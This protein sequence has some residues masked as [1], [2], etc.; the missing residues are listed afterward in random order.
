MDGAEGQEGGRAAA[1]W[2]RMRAGETAGPV[3]PQ[4]D[5]GIWFIGRLRTPWSDPCAC[6]R[7][8]DAAAG[9]LCRIELDPLWAE[10][11]D[12]LRPGPVQLLYWMHLGRRDLRRQSPKDDGTTR[13][14]FALRSP[15]RPNPIASSEVA[16]L[17]LDGADLLVR[18][19]DCTDGT[20]LL[21]IKPVH[22]S[23]K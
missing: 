20:P 23:L 19:L 14:T 5:A 15:M 13:G 21:D 18:G 9:P 6:P 4:S 16:F 1:P 17:G 11:L 3:P 22:G 10:A 8:G 7:R 12:G 2:N